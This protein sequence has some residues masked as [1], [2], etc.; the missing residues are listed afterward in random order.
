MNG[1]E[2][3]RQDLQTCPGE[4]TKVQ[5]HRGDMLIAWFMGGDKKR[6]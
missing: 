3:I 5:L 2:L 1:K 4:I 6:Y